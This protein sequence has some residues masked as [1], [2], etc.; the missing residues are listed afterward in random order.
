MTVRAH[1]KLFIY[2]VHEYSSSTYIWNIHACIYLSLCSLSYYFIYTCR[3]KA[4]VSKEV[5][6]PR[7]PCAKSYDHHNL[8]N[9]NGMYVSE[10]TTDVFPLTL[11]HFCPFFLQDLSSDFNT[12]A[13]KAG[14]SYPF[15]V[16]KS[17][18]VF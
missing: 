12:S 14:I 8:F 5:T 18:T 7:V 16:C 9:P 4:D 10:K 17:I 2:M 13:T 1:C 3:Y 15:R 6:E 11:S